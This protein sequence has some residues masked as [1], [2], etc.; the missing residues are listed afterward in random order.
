M[1]L[2]FNTSRLMIAK[3]ATLVYRSL[4]AAVQIPAGGH[5]IADRGPL[6]TVGGQRPLLSCLVA[7]VG[8]LV[9]WT[10]RLSRDGGRSAY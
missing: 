7:V 3:A 6:R 5:L 1:N 10:A 2:V 8:I 4:M 9:S